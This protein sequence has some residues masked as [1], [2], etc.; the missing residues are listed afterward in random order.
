M[1]ST[2][3]TTEKPVPYACGK[4]TRPGDLC[5]VRLRDGR[6]PH[7]GTSGAVLGASKY[8][9]PMS[10]AAP[11]EPGERS[12]AAEPL[13]YPP[14]MVNPPGTKEAHTLGPGDFFDF[15]GED[16]PCVEEVETAYRR[17]GIGPPPGGEETEAIH[18]WSKS[19][20]LKVVRP[21]LVRVH[22]Q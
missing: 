17:N 13:S 2:T 8:G 11:G 10:A 21:G 6:C 16:G 12:A 3:L 20:K 18:I 5:G 9:S 22:G 4:P 19:G 7:H 15:G 1:S 14:T